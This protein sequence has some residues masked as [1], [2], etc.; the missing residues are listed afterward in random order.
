MPWS[1]RRSKKIGGVRF[2]I[3]KRGLT[4][5]STGNRFLGHSVG[6][7]GVT[8]RMS[9]PGTG[10]SYRSKAGGCALVL[11]LGLLVLASLACGSGSS[12]SAPSATATP[13]RTP[14]PTP[15]L[16]PLIVAPS[17]TVTADPATATV[18]P[19]VTVEPSVTVEPATA[20]AEPSA[21]PEPT[22]V[23]TVEPLPTVVPVR[24]VATIS[25]NVV[26]CSGGCV[27]APDPSCAIKGNVNSS[28]DRIY[29]TPGQ[30]DYERTEIKPEEGD[31]W[32]CTEAEAQAAGFRH[33]QR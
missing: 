26:T 32:F 20:T 9:I 8:R 6:K 11:A 7:R 5:V 25:V 16:I 22:A 14:R 24:A 33:A 2:N 4:S 21:T 27:V 19:T 13:T 15:T 23:P 30:R 18:E 1:F 10:I 29:H 17:A 28:K 12:R 31:R 3:G